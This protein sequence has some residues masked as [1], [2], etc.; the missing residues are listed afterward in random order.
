MKKLLALF[1]IVSSISGK[2]LDI[3]VYSNP[4]RA[5][6]AKIYLAADLTAAALVGYFS[7]KFFIKNGYEHTTAVTTATVAAFSTASDI[8]FIYQQ[9]EVKISQSK[10]QLA[11]LELEAIFNNTVE[12]LTA[13]FEA[14]SDIPL[15]NA[16]S[17]IETV[18]KIVNEN[19]YTLT[20]IVK[21]YPEF[22]EQIN[23]ILTKFINIKST[24]V[25]KVNEIR[26]HENWNFQIQLYYERELSKNPN[27]YNF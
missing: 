9:P 13:M 20:N 5:R 10:K 22:T 7:T 17:S 25:N 19:I 14:S 4:T 21:K 27:Y 16:Y 6:N 1:L 26:K 8:F 2:F 18:K 11:K 15:V 12:Q 23:A 24:I 3:N